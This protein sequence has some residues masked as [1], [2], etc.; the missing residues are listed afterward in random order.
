LLLVLA[1]PACGDEP[2]DGENDAALESRALDLAPEGRDGCL[3]DLHASDAS[4]AADLAE[5]RGEPGSGDG[6]VGPEALDGSDSLPSEVLLDGDP[7][8][9][10]SLPEAVV[11]EIPT[12]P[13]CEEGLPCDDGDSCSTDDLCVGGVCAGTPYVCDDTRP[14]TLDSCDGLGNCQYT[15]KAG[16][17]L[18]NGVCAKAGEKKGDNQCLICDPDEDS[19]AWHQEQFLP[20]D[21]GEACTAD[22]KCLDGKCKGTVTPCFDGNDCT[23]DMC[24][25]KAGCKYPPANVPCD[26]K[27][28]CTAL[29][30]CEDGE[31]LGGP[32]I[33]CDDKNLC[34]VDSCQ[35]GKGC[36]HTLLDG[37]PCDD[38]DS[39]TQGDVC[40]E[41]SCQPG[42]LLLQCDDYNDCTD[43]ICD[44][45]AACTYP[46]AGNPCCIN[47][48]NICDDKDPCTIDSCN[49]DTGQC[50]YLPNAGPCSDK[51]ACTT[52]DVCVAGV[53]QGKPADCD[54]KNPCT[55]DF[56][57]A[58]VGCVHE[59]L[60][61]PCDDKS[62]CTL[63]DKCVGGECTGAK[64]NC[65]D[66]N[67]CTDDACDPVLGCQHTFGAAPCN[68]LDLCTGGDHC[69][70]GKCVGAP[71]TCDDSNPCTNDSCSPSAGCQNTFNSAPC[72][73]G[74]DCTE[75]DHC[76]GGKCTP[77]PA[78][79]P[80]CDYEFSETVNRV[81]TMKIST[82]AKAENALDLD[83]NGKPDNSMAGIA[84]MANA[85]LQ[86]S[87]DKGSLHLLFE[88]HDFK[89]N[90]SVYELAVFIGQLAAGFESCAFKTDFCGYAVDQAT[91]DFET[92]QALVVFDN[93]S[94]FQGKLVA[95]GKKYKFPWEV[96]ISEGTNLPIT[97][98]YAT[99]K[100]DVTVKQGKVTKL[101]GILGGAIPKQSFV[102]AINAVPDDK[103][104]LPKSMIL[105]LVQVMVVNDIDTNGDGTADAASIAIPIEGIAAGIIGFK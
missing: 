72:S 85:P 93:A 55:M 17:C 19:F 33:P 32:G 96:P 64:I 105:Q 29:D 89:S 42:P 22:D 49:P 101:S 18:I 53:C 56:C 61:M 80:T 28:P 27:D 7:A 48:I 70:Q 95:G 26:D 98:Y 21:D 13:P 57:K 36:F 52:G 62:V 82:D 75:P 73:D 14:C 71:K 100:A 77:G 94:V 9:L 68:D 59:D 11:E 34:T 50:L 5:A 91:L 102:D 79:C 60:D 3:L 38:G 44:K 45:I 30:F 16:K 104:P 23:W 87:L 10:P 67:L 20:C 43:D 66:F 35:P 40:S 74:D 84:S 41:G 6:M 54:D 15:L 4:D 1:T 99:I 69:V 51:D 8:D 37:K 83:G 92:C 39:C 25:S 88:H 65:N 63:N 78:I 86:D 90:G 58:K 97:L 31:C 81:T 24:D 47:D 103:L 12:P 46:L 2:A 76:A